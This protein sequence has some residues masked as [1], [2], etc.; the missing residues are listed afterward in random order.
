M[1]TVNKRKQILTINL[2]LLTLKQSFELENL[3]SIKI[4]ETAGSADRAT[5]TVLLLADH[6]RL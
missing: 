5:I 3:T 2:N 1:T 4:I 6:Y